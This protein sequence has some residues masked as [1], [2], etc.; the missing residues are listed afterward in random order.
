M[1]SAAQEFDFLQPRGGFNFG[2]THRH[3]YQSKHAQYNRDQ[4]AND[5]Y[6]DGQHWGTRTL[7]SLV[8]K[9]TLRGIYHVHERPDVDYMESY[10]GE[11]ELVTMLSIQV[12]QQTVQ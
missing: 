10:F 2:W 6:L 12:Q 5:I 1:E 11:S 7:G 8:H 3:Y 9:W 4:F